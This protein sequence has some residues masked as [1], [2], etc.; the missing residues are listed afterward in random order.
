MVVGMGCVRQCAQCRY[1][2][3]PKKFSCVAKV[4]A[5]GG[6]LVV[7]GSGVKSGVWGPGGGLRLIHLH[8]YA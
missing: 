3:S 8:V 5:G 7:H 6:G 1:V 2:P 4:D